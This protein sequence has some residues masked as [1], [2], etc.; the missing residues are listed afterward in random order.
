MWFVEVCMSSFA[1]D[2]CVS[3]LQRCLCGKVAETDAS[4]SFVETL[5]ER[6]TTRTSAASLLYWVPHE[7]SEVSFLEERR[8]TSIETLLDCCFL[9]GV[10]HRMTSILFERSGKKNKTQREVFGA[11][12][13]S[14]IS[15][16]RVAHHESQAPSQ[17]SPSI[18]Y[19][20]LLYGA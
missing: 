6:D 9:G 2:S 3:S 1:C 4:M 12:L 15:C 5:L 20:S 17:P 14:G 10:V 18:R 8:T 16:D 11:P 19:N 7:T 13:A